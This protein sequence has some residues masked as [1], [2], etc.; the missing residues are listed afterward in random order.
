MDAEGVLPLIADAV[1][2][3]CRKLRDSARPQ[4]LVGMADPKASEVA[5]AAGEGGSFL[6][7][8]E[9][10]DLYSIGAFFSDEHP[11][12]VD[13]VVARAGEIEQRGLEGYAATRARASRRRS[14]R[15]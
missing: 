5:A 1:N 12:L 11:D 3:F 4:Y 9:N 15:C 7:S 10:T 8:L 14:R 13:E 2:L 6:E